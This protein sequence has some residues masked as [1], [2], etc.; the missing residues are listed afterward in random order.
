MWMYKEAPQPDMRQR[1]LNIFKVSTIEIFLIFVREA[2]AECCVSVPD[3]E[4]R[5]MFV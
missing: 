5:L 4:V 2:D 1:L 3:T